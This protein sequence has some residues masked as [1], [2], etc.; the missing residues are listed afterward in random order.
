M[1][2]PSARCGSWWTAV[3]ASAVRRTSSSTQSE[4][5]ARARRKAAT[6]FSGWVSGRAAPRW[7]M[8]SGLRLLLI[9]APTV[10]LESV[11]PGRLAHGGSQPVHVPWAWYRRAGGTR[12]GERTNPSVVHRGRFR[13][14]H[15][16]FRHTKSCLTGLAR[17]RFVSR[18]R[19]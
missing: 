6:V 4:A 1:A 15:D 8:M 18:Y 5:T 19:P 7:A 11:A 10:L 12:I 2:R 14:T 17:A 16:G 13:G 9:V 3:W